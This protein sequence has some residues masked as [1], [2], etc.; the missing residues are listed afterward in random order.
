MGTDDWTHNDIAEFPASLTE[1]LV[2]ESAL[3]GY[4]LTRTDIPWGATIG[5]MFRLKV[6][7]VSRCAQVIPQF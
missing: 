4:L 1:F 2:L 3:N 7:I 5:M 6:T